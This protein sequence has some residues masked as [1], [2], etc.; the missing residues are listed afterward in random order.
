MS[1]LR[2]RVKNLD[3]F[4]Q[5]LSSDIKQEAINQFKLV[6]LFKQINP[7]LHVCPSGIST[8]GLLEKGMLLLVYV[9]NVF[10]RIMSCCC[11]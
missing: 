8:G 9:N 10:F 3:S 4:Q 11:V 5:K 1:Q 7:N 6:H 2:N